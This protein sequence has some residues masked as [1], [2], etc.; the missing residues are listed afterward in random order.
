MNVGTARYWILTPGPSPILL[1][2]TND[3]FKAKTAR[4]SKV[5]DVID[6]G[7]INLWTGAPHPPQPRETLIKQIERV[8]A[9][10]EGGTHGLEEPARRL[11]ALDLDE[12]A[13]HPL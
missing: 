7:P 13:R 6:R 1:E 8:G 5:L 9:L 4:E 10:M 11:A 2:P 12:D 3:P